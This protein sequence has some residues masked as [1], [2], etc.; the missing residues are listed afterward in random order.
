MEALDRSVARRIKPKV[1]SLAG[2]PRPAGAAKLKGHRDFYRIRIGD[3]R[4]VYSI[5]DAHEVVEI[6]IVAHRRE[7]YRDL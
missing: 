5:D 6:V 7:V 4:V 3:F 1:L 2:E